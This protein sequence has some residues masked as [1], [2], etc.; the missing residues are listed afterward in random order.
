MDK[1]DNTSTR[2]RNYTFDQFK[3]SLT[4]MAQ[5]SLPSFDAP[6]WSYESLAS[7][8]SYTEKEVRNIVESGGRTAQR[9][10]SRK[11]FNEN[12]FYRQIV[13]HY[14]TL[15]KNQ[16]VLIPST[17]FGTSLQGS[18]NLKRYHNALTLLDK[19]KIKELFT[20]ISITV[21]VDG[22]YYGLLTKKTRTD[23][24]LMDLP[25]DYCRS[26][27]QGADGVPR[28][29][30][31]V[32]Y[33]SRIREKKARQAALSLFPKY[34]VSHFHLWERGKRDRWLLIPSDQGVVFE[35]FNSRPYFLSVLPSLVQYDEA[36][37]VEMEKNLEEIKKILVQHIP[38]LNDGTLVFEP[39][40]A[41]E[42]HSGTVD[43]MGRNNPHLSVLTSYGE[44]EVVQS[45]TTN[46]ITHTA[47]QQ[48][49]DNV[50]G[51][52]GVSPNLFASKGNS[53]SK[54]SLQYDTSVMMVLGE[55]YATFIGETINRAYGTT[56]L[57]FRFLMLPVTLYN[58][59]EYVSD[60]FKLAQSGYS[61]LLPAIAQ[62]MSQKD[63]LNLKDL[64]NDLL[65]LPSKLQP[66]RSAYTQSGDEDKGGRPEEP[67]ERTE[68][69]EKNRV[70][71]DEEESDE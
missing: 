40:E 33:F 10:L 9:N 20:R 55:K 16:G 52:A 60:Y 19:M 30:F 54:I 6:F 2:P 51:K 65:D 29:E 34:I 39:P 15:L 27:Y 13:M 67:D 50:F 22:I 5:K 23:F 32:S 63:L 62:G 18:P 45:Q 61:F 21:L 48:M 59:Q 28:L 64:E 71:L 56:Q 43:M 38:H 26:H 1:V 8:K 25:F 17:S 12:G 3:D 53:S 41:E 58:E 4:N 37:V 68:K 70:S 35:L 44:V 31:D 7:Q 14:G 24:S 69:T 57:S 36:V 47:L 49:S 42:M 11:F 66:L 46:S